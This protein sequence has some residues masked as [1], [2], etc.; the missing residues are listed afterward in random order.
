MTNISPLNRLKKEVGMVRHRT[1]LLLLI[2]IIWGI[3]LMVTAETISVSSQAAQPGDTVQV[4]I[5]LDKPANTLGAVFTINYDTGNLTLN[6]VISPFFQSFAQQWAGSSNPPN[7]VPPSQVT[8]DGVTYVQPL[9]INS[10]VGGIML[11]AVNIESGNMENDLF[12]L[13][14]E[15][16]P[17]I[18]NGI[19]PI[20]ISTSYISE[21]SAGYPQSGLGIPLIHPANN[22]A[23]ISGKISVNT[24]ITDNDGDGIDD[25]W[26]M[27][28][29]GN[30]TTA[31][32]LT[33]YDQDG[34]SD[35]QEYLNQLSGMLDSNGTQ[36]NPT[37]ANASGGVGYV[38]PHP[39]S[40]ILKMLIP[41]LI[42]NAKSL[43]Q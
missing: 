31:S 3:P 26:E 8:V 4:S 5:S 1:M 37:V 11:A 36:F 33:D 15:L 6:Q 22:T 7:P 12:I 29:F 13:E 18:P 32:A 28:Y 17:S 19:Y 25:G 27:T 20:S 2:L 39:D 43:K 14:F 35:L 9:V 10:V 38:E 41:I 30:L 23:V 34:Y 16:S 40:N 21:G 42:E 24:T